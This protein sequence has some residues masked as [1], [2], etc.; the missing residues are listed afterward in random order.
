M[1]SI[2]CLKC[3]KRTATIDEIEE[4]TINNRN[5]LK[6]RCADC[7]IKKN[8]FIKKNKES[9]IDDKISDIKIDIIN[10]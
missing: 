1:S 3:K 2:Y 5:I 7:G 9:M 4:M 6:G 8:K 10:D